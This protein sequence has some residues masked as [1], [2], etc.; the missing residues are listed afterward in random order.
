MAKASGN[1]KSTESGKTSKKGQKG[2][3]KA[4][5]EELIALVPELDAEGL[6]FLIEQARVHLYNMRVSELEAAAVEAERASTRSRELGTGE[7]R[8]KAG[9]PA[10]ARGEFRVEA[11][12]D[13]STYDIVRDGKW[14]MFSSEE[15]LAMVRICSSK[16][17]VAQVSG[18]LYRWL[19]AERSDAINDFPI[20]G[21]ADP[22]LKK[23]VS[24][25][26]KT[27]TIKGS[28]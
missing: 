4:L 23:L 16:D 11:A 7:A 13:G 10:G 21:L 22:S 25:L 3:A 5:A 26:R 14:K 20:A 9:A 6:A 19:L 28:R 1:A 12:S 18:R 24:L 2:A 27:F 8:S 15:M 17:P